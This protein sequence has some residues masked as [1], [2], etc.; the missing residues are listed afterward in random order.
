VA[1]T[2]AAKYPEYI[3]KIILMC[4]IGP[5]GVPFK[6]RGKTKKMEGYCKKKEDLL[7]DEPTMMIIKA[8]KEKNIEVMKAIAESGIFSNGK[9]PESSVYERY[10]QE[11][12]LQR[13]YLDVCYG[14]MTYNCTNEDSVVCK[15]NGLVKKVRAPVLIIT[16]ESDVLTPSKLGGVWKEQLGEV[17]QWKVL[18]RS[19]HFPL[20]DNPEDLIRETKEF[21][22]GGPKSKL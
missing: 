12:L 21:L 6:Q 20:V 4:P 5:K 10:L 13:N 9:K 17:A 3:Q 2:F 15:G 22:M 8:Q 18:K 7:Y 14:L 19:G 1:I 16:G 11:M